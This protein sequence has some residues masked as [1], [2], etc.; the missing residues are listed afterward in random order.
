MRYEGSQPETPPSVNRVL[1]F[2][3]YL[4]VIVILFCFDYMVVNFLFR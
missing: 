1:Y 3:N 4:L 2:L